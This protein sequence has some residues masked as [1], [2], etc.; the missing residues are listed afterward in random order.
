MTAA[1]KI[2]RLKG[3][4]LLAAIAVAPKHVVVGVIGRKAQQKHRDN[5]NEPTEL[6]VATV[7][8]INHFGLGVPARAFMTIALE[9]KRDEIAG[10]QARIA[11]QLVKGRIG[12]EQA[13]G[14]LGTVVVDAVKKTIVEGVEPPN[15]ERTIAA[16][17]S[18]T[19]LINRGQLLGA[20]SYAIREGK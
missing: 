1:V 20:V 15:S 12:Y 18:S 2:K 11:A 17:G 4:E 5:D 8:A 9:R 10:M 16:K 13:L 6:T 14:L 19:P 3:E 7:A